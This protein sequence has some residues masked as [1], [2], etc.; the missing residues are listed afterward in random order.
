MSTRTLEGSTEPYP[1]EHW[2]A[3]AE[4]LAPALADAV[5][6][7]LRIEAV[8]GSR[9]LDGGAR[10]T[11]LDGGGNHNVFGLHVADHACCLKVL[12]YAPRPG[13]DCDTVPRREVGGMCVLADRG[14][15][16]CPRVIAWSLSPAWIL[17]ELLPGHH[18]GNT[19]LTPAQLSDLAEATRE[20]CAITPETAGE[21]LWDIDWNI[22]FQ[23]FDQGSADLK[24]GILGEFQN[25]ADF[26][27]FHKPSK[28]IIEGHTDSDGD[29]EYNNDL[30]Q[31]RA[32][33]VRET[34]ISQYEF[35]GPA[36]LEARGYGEERP[37]FENTSPENKSLNRRIEIVVWWEDLEERAD[38]SEDEEEEEGQQQSLQ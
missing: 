33:A 31:R 13:I 20:L 19:E 22:R 17:T 21:A 8:V 5:E 3:H 26:I 12:R 34:M 29:D 15:A 10:L 9:D 37:L 35:I 11:A 7:A 16:R 2:A 14:V 28:L 32:E 36:M 23:L 38:Q 30:S 6:Q 4:P 1:L 18:L 27:R 25:V 24:A